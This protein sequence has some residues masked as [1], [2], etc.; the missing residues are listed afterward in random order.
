[1]VYPFVNQEYG[2]KPSE[3]DQE[4][5]QVEKTENRT[6]WRLWS[7]SLIKQSESN[8]H[9]SEFSRAIK[10][11]EKSPRAKVERGEIFRLESIL[12]KVE[13]RKLIQTKVGGCKREL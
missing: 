1:M 6:S 12:T 5:S 11:N 10:Q 9:L 13:V 3:N 2:V 7:Q 8:H 4:D